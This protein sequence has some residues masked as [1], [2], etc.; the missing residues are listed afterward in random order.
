LLCQDAGFFRSPVPISGVFDMSIEGA[1]EILRPPEAPGKALA[2]SSQ[3][4]FW[5]QRG[6]LASAWAWPG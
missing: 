4:A 1:L 2:T 6:L 3:A 5:G